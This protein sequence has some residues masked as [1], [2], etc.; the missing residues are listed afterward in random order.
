MVSQNK[1]NKF[2]INPDDFESYEEFRKEYHKAWHQNN[3]NNNKKQNRIKKYNR[4]YKLKVN[5]NIQIHE[6]KKLMNL[7]NYSCEIC[8]M[9]NKEHK[10]IFKK[11]L[12]LDH[13]HNNND[14]RG[15]L[16][17]YCNMIEGYLLNNS[18]SIDKYLYNFNSYM[19]K[20]SPYIKALNI[21]RKNGRKQKVTK[22][23]RS[24]NKN[25]T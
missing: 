6:Y 9:T 4:F 3:K 18:I 1:N 7:A 20:N 10:K 24:N 19:N 21:W 8:N 17:N 25:A 2:K 14:I 12:S 16:C 23:F 13:N 22:L 15:I 11:P 5:Y